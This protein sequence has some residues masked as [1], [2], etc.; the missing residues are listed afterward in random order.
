MFI[1]IQDILEQCLL[2]KERAMIPAA[3]H[4]LEYENPEAFNEEV[5]TFLAKY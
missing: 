4:G 3:S 2:N 1:Q 5:L